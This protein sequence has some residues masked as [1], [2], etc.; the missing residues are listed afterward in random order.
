MR[1]LESEGVQTIVCPLPPPQ[2]LALAIR[3]RLERAA[4]D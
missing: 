4:R 1:W 3:D 2:D